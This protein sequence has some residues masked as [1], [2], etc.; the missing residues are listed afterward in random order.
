MEVK[1]LW[2]IDES[3]AWR[4]RVRLPA[5]APR[6]H[7]QLLLLAACLA[8]GLSCACVAASPGPY[9]FQER[10]IPLLTS[11]E[12]SSRLVIAEEGLQFLR[13]LEGKIAVVTV[14]GGAKT[15][16]SYLMNNMLGVRHR[17]GFD[18]GPSYIPGTR[19]ILLWGMPQKEIING[20]SVTVIYVDT[21]GLGAPGTL[22]DSYDP[23]LCTFAVILSSSFYYNT[24]GQITQNA[25]NML[26]SVAV[27]AKIFEK[28]FN[29]TFPMPPIFWLVQSHGFELGNSSA[30]DY[31]WDFVLK[32]KMVPPSNQGD[33]RTQIERFNEVIDMIE[34]N[35]VVGQH[36]NHILLLDHPSPGLKASALQDLPFNQTTPAYQQQVL[37]LRKIVKERLQVKAF[38]KAKP[39]TGAD[40]AD[41][42][43]RL[44]PYLNSVHGSVG[45]A[46]LREIANQVKEQCFVQYST[47][48]TAIPK[49]TEVEVLTSCHNWSSVQAL[50]KFN[51]S[52]PGAVD[53][54]ENKEA[55]KWLVAKMEDAIARI[56]EDNSNIA[57]R[58]CAAVARMLL[59]NNII[60]PDYD[61]EERLQTMVAH[62]ENSFKRDCT[63]PEEVKVRLWLEV[64]QPTIHVK[65]TSIRRSQPSECVQMMT[66]F[67]L[68]LFAPSLFIIFISWAPCT[69]ASLAYLFRCYLWLYGITVLMAVIAGNPTLV[70]LVLPAEASKVLDSTSL[71]RIC[72]GFSRMRSLL[73]WAISYVSQ[74]WWWFVG[75]TQRALE[76]SDLSIVLSEFKSN[77][78]DFLAVIAVLLTVS[79]LI[80]QALCC[81]CRKE[82]P[83]D[84]IAALPMVPSPR[85][86]ATSVNA[87]I[88]AV[89]TKR[90]PHSAPVAYC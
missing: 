5:V 28:E 65:V 27:V 43:E 17:Q 62:V 1:G 68:E 14:A 50:D 48:V 78:G 29:M 18:V 13:A 58:H 19:G 6:G 40:L 21:E 88:R 59:Q 41:I 66:N 51:D 64:L 22:V 46:L 55:R 20:E 67:V 54:P 89:G 80:L 60:D 39:V 9:E 53:L 44:I 37:E 33:E 85:S 24:M 30:E 45:P 81:R 32:K 63:G 7:G 31:L 38:L 72:Q 61:S 84:R 34:K 26:H 16:K 75:V 71:Q 11:D 76:S 15:G 52:C 83:I 8:F 4:A 3:D 82:S 77:S 79:Y 87:P 74:R 35:F 12:S 23:K 70:K 10:P 56:L 49:P 2:E 86:K 57:W 90:P 73:S 69:P 42:T 25:V 47:N 36:L